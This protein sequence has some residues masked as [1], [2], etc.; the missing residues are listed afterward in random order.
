MPKRSVASIISLIKKE[1]RFSYTV[2]DGSFTIT[3]DDYVPY[4]CTAIHDGGNIRADIRDKISLSKFE[5]WQ[6]E[7]PYTGE[8]I[9]SLPIRII[10]HDSRYEY[11]LNRPPSECVYDSAWGK[12][13]WKSPLTQIQKKKSLKKH[14]QYYRILEALIKK[15]EE[16]FHSC[17]VFDIHS[18]NYKRLERSD[19]PVFNLGTKFIPKKFRPFLDKWVEH[20]HTIELPYIKNISRENDVFVGKGHQL[21]FLTEKFSNTL[22]LATEIKKVYVDEE[23][24]DTHPEVIQALKTEL[25]RV[26]TAQ[27]QYFANE[28]TN[29]TIDKRHGLL[30]SNVQKKVKDIDYQINLLLKDFDLLSFVS[31][32][33]IESEKRKFL[34]SKNK[35]APNFKYSPLKFDVSF[36]K[37]SLYSLPIDDISDISLQSMYREI[38]EAY[39][40]QMDMLTNRQD[41]KFLYSSL[42]YFGAPSEV[43]IKI[44][45]FLIMTP[46]YTPKKDT[47]FV[48]EAHVLKYCEDMIKDLNFKGK[49]ST[50]KNL[51]STA[52]F[53]PNRNLLKIKK[54]I[55]LKKHFAKALAHHEVGVHMLTTENALQ[56]KLKIFNLGFPLNTKTQEGLAILSEYLSGYLTVDRLKDLA[57]RVLAV[58][59]MIMNDDFCKTFNYLV[60]KYK[61][62]EEK[63]FYLTTRVYRGGGFTKDYLYLTGFKEIFN[64]YLNDPAKVNALFVGKTS[65]EYIEVLNELIQR[66]LI[67]PPT[68]IPISFENPSC[69]L[70]PIT[71]YLLE[72]FID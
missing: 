71:K 14:A 7:D 1:E 10:V 50:T 21:Q 45:K 37:R 70:D 46:S 44:A 29:I 52:I 48:D 16:L 68:K 63:A 41:K 19:A 64:L 9:S 58:S 67:S 24:G 31:P 62:N 27:T 20:L 57:L 12:K 32:I 22:V 38:I 11:D 34:N 53:L 43:D 18:Y 39:S 30:S 72:I 65:V 51:A 59:H 23:T 35:K 61:L 3:V 69:E 56:Q 13:V 60:E 33:N 25:K 6:E 17:L 54:E 2:E 42:K 4:V 5:R 55:K 28:V 15:L 49:V 47:E 40:S 36:L 26:I 66:E 8:F